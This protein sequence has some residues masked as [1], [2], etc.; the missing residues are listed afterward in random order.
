MAKI[1]AAEVNKL[2]KETG[3]GMM[4]CKNALVEAEGNFETAIEVLRK[5]GQKVAAKRAD[6]DS[7]EGAVIAKVNTEA[8]RGVVV[9]LNCE[10]DFVAKNDSFVDLANN[11]AE[12]ALTTASK[13]EFLAANFNGMTVADKL[14]E[15]TGI[16]GEKIEI[17]AFDKIE[18][19]FVGSY[20]HAGN[21]IAT[22][23]GLSVAVEGASVVAKDVAM[24]VAAMSPIALDENGVDQAT[25]EKEI[26]IAKDQLRQEGKPEAMLDN[27]AKGKLKRFFKDNTLVN[28]DFIKDSKQSVA[29]YVKTLGDVTIVDFKR[30]ALG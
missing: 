20:I 2:R 27:I 18:A 23:V 24:Q 22:L 5:K 9:S 28:Q 25:I 8:T 7:S 10:T 11:L 3:A 1:T 26:E 14:L 6:R 12:V 15:Q 17:G 4:D 13:E 16:I 29:Q 30:A 19:P 21:K